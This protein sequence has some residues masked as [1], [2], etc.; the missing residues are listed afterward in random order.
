MTDFVGQPLS[1]RKQAARFAQA[2]A[3]LT[4]VDLTTRAIKMTRQRFKNLG[5]VSD[6]QVG[7][8]ENLGFPDNSF[9]TVYSW[10]V[11]H[12]NPDTPKAV[13]EILR[14]LKPGGETRIMIYHKY[15]LIGVMLW[16][17]YALFA[18]KPLTPFS[19]IYAKYLESP[20]TKAYNEAEPRS[21]FGIFEKVSITLQ[22]THGDLLS[23]QAGHRHAGVLMK[24][25]RKLWLRWFFMRFCRRNGL[26][27]LIEATKPV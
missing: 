27:M 22:L 24:L 4:G 10:G 1:S 21:L 2:G 5:L 7:D 20:G 17:R 23:S 13:H 19:A 15:S 12:H 8:A 18:G 25:A 14:V 16:L 26:F 9:D 11:I 3:I 6:F